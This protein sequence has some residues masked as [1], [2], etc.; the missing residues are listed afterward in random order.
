MSQQSHENVRSTAPS[1]TPRGVALL[2]DPALNKGTAFTEAERD[3]L[4]LRGLLP[5]HVSTQE[6]QLGRLLENFRRQPTDLEKYVSLRSLHDRNE[7][8]FF[9]LLM[10]YPDEMMPIVY[11]PTVGLACQR[12]THIFQRPHGIFVSAADRGR[13]AEV[14]ANWPHRKVAIIVVSDGERI[15]GLGDLGANGMGIPIGK[16]AL[17]TACAGVPPTACLPVLLDVGTNNSELLDDPLYIG[18]HQSRVRGEIYDALVEEFVVAAGK[19]FPG[20][21]IQF[22]DFATHNAFRL[23]KNYRDRIPTF[24]DDIQGTAAVVLAGILSALRVTGGAL[25]EQTLLFQGAGEAATGIADLVVQAMVA[26]GM[27]EAQA[28]RRCWLVDSKGLVVKGRADLF[29][30][31]QPY[32]HDH[33]PVGSLLDAVKALRPT[34]IIG[35]AAVGGAFTEEVVRTMAAQ[36]KRPIVFA[37]SN[38]TSKSECTAAQAYGWSDGR[39]LFA[40]GSP[41]DPVTLGGQTHVPR[42]GNNSYIFPGVGLGVIVSGAS[43]VTDEMFMAAAHTLAEHVTEDDLRQG[44]LYPPLKNIRDVS[45]HIAAAVASVAYRR[46]LSKGPE[47]VDLLGFTKSQMYQPRYADYVAG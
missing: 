27:N 16:L 21:V 38:P 45:A 35:V 34:A 1:A 9:R 25:G 15:L 31:K 17:Y 8:L 2:Q 28:R 14:L 26:N 36:N 30:H 12:Y 33:A 29:A 44:S 32:A 4:H 39:A 24:N 47:P 11:T 43:R 46:G 19:L 13:V 5:P 22:E 42:Q 40:C 37:L 18:L 41:F 10:D 23:L 3:A 7:S 6:Q 20:V